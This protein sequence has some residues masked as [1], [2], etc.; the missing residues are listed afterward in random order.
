M[1][2]V[3]RRRKKSSGRRRRRKEPSG[4]ATVWARVSRVQP[5]LCLV[6]PR[7]T[8]VLTSRGFIQMLIR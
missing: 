7:M 6:G 3:R 8:R 2:L 4:G 5:L 1:K